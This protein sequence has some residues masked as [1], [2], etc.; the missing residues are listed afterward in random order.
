MTG[1][2]ITNAVPMDVLQPGQ[3]RFA[4]NGRTYNTPDERPTTDVR[5][6]KPE[7]FSTLGVRLARG[8]LF[9]ELDHEDAAPVILIN[10]T[11]PAASGKGATPSAPRCPP[12]TVRTWS[13]VV[14]IVADV[15]TF[16][17]NRESTPQVYIPLRQAGG[18]AGRC[19]CA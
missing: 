8:R 15:K 19:W 17:L 16:G 6:A 11:L 1:A 9:T 18:L 7:C 12:T 4:V 13:T 14:G 2:A 10:E 5:I 3:T